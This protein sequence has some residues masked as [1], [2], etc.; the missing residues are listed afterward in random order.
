MNGLTP[1]E[2]RIVDRFQQRCSSTAQKPLDQNRQ[3]T[4]Q[5][6]SIKFFWAAGLLSLY[7]IFSLVAQIV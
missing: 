3:I 4:A 1:R 7:A 2:V 5:T 6:A